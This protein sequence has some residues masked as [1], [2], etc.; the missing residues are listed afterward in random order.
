MKCTIIRQ[1]FLDF[2]KRNGHTLVSSSSLIPAED[3]TLLFTNAGMNQFKD[4]FLGTQKRP[5]TR[6]ASIQKC[7]RAGGKHNDLEQVGFTA[8][9]LTFF[10]MMGNFSF[11]DYFKTQAIAFAWDFLTKEMQIDSSLLYPTVFESDDEAF[12]IWHEQIGVPQNKILRLGAKDNFWQM[13]ETGPCG[14]C[15]EILV[16][17][18]ERYSC[19][20]QCKPG[21]ECSRYMEVWN[22][23]FMQYDRQADGTLTP[24]EKPGVD[25]GMGFER[26]CTIMQQEDSVFR[27]DV[28][29]PLLQALEKST[30]IIYAT[31]SQKTQCAFHVLADHVRS[32]SL[33]IADGCTPS[34]EGRGYVLRKIIRRAALFAQKLS[35]SPT[36]FADL[37]RVFIAMMGDIYPELKESST[38][39]ISLLQQE[40][41][42][43]S[44]HLIAGQALLAKYITELQQQQSTVIPGEIAFKLHDT[45]GFPLELTNVIAQEHNLTVD[46][47][48]FD[49]AMAQQQEQ[50]GKKQVATQG[51]LD[52]PAGLSSEF[53]GYKTL[54]IHA[55]ILA[56]T[57]DEHDAWIV[58][59]Q[60]PFYVECGGQVND[61]GWVSVHN[62][63]YPV[64]DLKRVET[65]PGK[66]A[67]AVRIAGAANKIQAGDLAHCTVNTETRLDTVRNHTATHLLQAAL[68][69]VLGKSVKQAGSVVAPHYLRFDFTHPAALTPEQIVAIEKIVN[70]RIQEDI[71]TNIYE[72]T[73]EDA[74]KRGVISFFGEKYNPECVRVVEIPGFSAELCGGTHAPRTGIIGCFKIVSETALAVG[75]RR[76]VAYT[77][78][79]ALALFQQSYD[80]TSHLATHFKVKQDQVCSAVERLSA[81]L[82]TAQ[83]TM[84]LLRRATLREQMAGWIASMKPIAGVP[85]LYQELNAVGAD[86]LKKL[87]SELEKN[88][89]GLFVLLTKDG[90]AA[91]VQY[92]VWVSTAYHGSITARELVPLLQ[93]HGLRGGGSAQAVQGGGTLKGNLRAD[94]EKYLSQK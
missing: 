93:E 11:G 78:R 85:F 12:N 63:S 8:R 83:K 15:S 69:H 9:H 66:F 47:A 29:A 45:Y 92:L 91:H 34:N 18:G 3:P 43:F 59:A 20:T 76:I 56:A 72:T 4:V 36:L 51:T 31:A 14:P 65:A 67:I 17:R 74:K 68:M 7:V 89:P 48:G 73:L 21:C 22:L 81:Q 80:T 13:G 6:A 38:L 30:K 40:V 26:L 52:I 2:F 94:I 32:C 42:R 41:D 37:A 33:L 16:D 62:V 55:P 19:G 60:S 58:T 71:S 70:E 10:E 35:E 75:V 44:T 50:S 77:G 23:V 53:V 54:E 49:R 61:Q 64:I 90:E 25:T 39:I 88:T 82:E 46:I 84:K 28:F 1:R 86:E 87:C 57:T 24:L 5:Y 79:G 27:T